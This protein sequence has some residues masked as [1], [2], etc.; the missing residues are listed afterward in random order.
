M[1]TFVFL[2]TKERMENPIT[3]IRE[4]TDCHC[5]I[6]PGIDDGAV[7]LS[8][9]LVLSERLVEFGYRRAIC[10]SHRNHLYQNTPEIIMKQYHILKD[11]LERRNIPLEI[12]P[13]M[14]YRIIEET[15]P[16]VLEKGW[17]MPWEGNHILVE[18]PISNPSRIGNLDPA[19]EIRSLLKNGYIPVL[20]HPERYLW[21]SEHHYRKYKD[22]GALFQR[23]VGAL[24]GMY[25]EK[26][27]QR[28]EYLMGEGMY[29][30]LAT[31]L[32]SLKYADYFRKI[33][34]GC[35]T[36]GA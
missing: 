28:A 10:T 25:G 29:D 32:H 7:D 23:N 20:A 6:L 17:L 5:H 30:L 12:I 4:R 36:S 19:E 24:E 9:S 14:E 8:D 27:S 16:E 13:S 34:F 15:W 3:E 1:P 22:A 35:L 21:C 18:L 2:K 31:D 11:E 33:G 26:V